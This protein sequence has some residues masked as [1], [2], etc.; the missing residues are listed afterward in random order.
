MKNEKGK[1]TMQENLDAMQIIKGNSENFLY[2]IAWLRRRYKLSRR[3][4]AKI[5]GIGILSVKKIE[6]G[7]LPKKLTVNAIDNIYAV[8]GVLP[9]DQFKSKLGE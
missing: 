4:M 9:E 6:K 5:L 7:K 1:R 3:D 2:N 8:F